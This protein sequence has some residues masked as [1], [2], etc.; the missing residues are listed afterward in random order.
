MRNVWGLLLD[1]FGQIGLGAESRY[2]DSYGTLRVLAFRYTESDLYSDSRGHLRIITWLL[3]N[4][5]DLSSQ[6]VSSIK[7][8]GAVLSLAYFGIIGDFYCIRYCDA[9]FQI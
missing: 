8:I 2:Q 5:K 6:G 7:F 4:G 3:L 1:W 9:D